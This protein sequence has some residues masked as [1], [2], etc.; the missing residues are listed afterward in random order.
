MIVSLFY[1][2][3]LT[4]PKSHRPVTVKIKVN[5][6]NNRRLPVGMVSDIED[7]YEEFTETAIRSFKKLPIGEAIDVVTK[8][9]TDW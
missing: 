2:R 5:S 1:P 3:E 6:V 8:A 4:R 9:M 7:D